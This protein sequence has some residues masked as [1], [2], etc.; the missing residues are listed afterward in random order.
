MRFPLKFVITAAVVCHLLLCAPLVISQARP[1][2]IATEEAAAPQN[3]AD[4]KLPLSATERGPIAIAA[5]SCEK[6]GDT[7]TLTGAVEIQYR[8]YVLRGDKMTYNSGSGGASAVGNVSLDGGPHDAHILADHGDYNVHQQTGKFYE[9]SGTTGARFQGKNVTLTSS[10]PV[11]F[12]GKEV[13]KTGPDE[14]IIYKGSVTSCELPRPK[15]TFSAAKIIVRVGDSA[16]VYNTIFRIRGIPVL[17]LPF[18]A[19]PVESLGRKSGFLVPSLGQ[20][21]TRGF[22]L[23]DSFYWAVNRSTDATVGAEYLSKRGWEL[24]DDFRI[25]PSDTSYLNLNFFGVLDRGVPNSTGGRTDQGGQDVKLNGESIFPHDVRGVVSLEYLSSFVFRQAFT[26]TFS[27]AVDSEVKSTAFLSK[28]FQGFSFNAFGSRYQNFQ[29]TN[30]NDVITILHAPGGESSSVDQRLGKSPLYASYDVAAEG[31]QRTEPGFE[32][33]N[34]VA[35][36]DVLP[37]VSMPLFYK[38]WSFRPEVDVRDT[39]YSESQSPNNVGL[40]VALAQ[41]LNRK[42]VDTSVALRPPTI[43]K[44]FD[45]TFAGRTLKHTLEPSLTYRYTNGVDNLGSTIRFDFRDILSDTNEVEY[46]LVQRLYLKPK[47]EDC[48]EP[49]TGSNSDPAGDAAG[50]EPAGAS[51]FVTWEVKQKYFF[52]PNFGGAVVNGRRNVLATTVDF[53]GIAFLT[54]PRRFSPLVSKL[55][56]RT[57]KNSDLGWQLDYDSKKGRINA[58]TF[59]TTFHFGD[60]FVEGSHAYLQV[61]GEIVTGT[62]QVPLPTCKAGTINQPSCVPGQFNQVRALLGYGKPNK[63]GLS[64][65]GSVGYDYFFK[66]LQYGATQ[67]SYNWD[68]CGVTL[69]Y[70][71]FALLSVRNENQYRFAFTLANIATFGNLK[72]QLRLF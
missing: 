63:L 66:F 1:C 16:K 61:P 26:Q 35:R 72:R 47:H 22:I 25:R 36:F 3:S 51:E 32:T 5:D 21:N 49:G 41:T 57:S 11:A 6:N 24:T 42:T 50:C 18:A 34:L 60:F 53:T 27:Q 46:G 30:A 15:W 62:N 64:A 70:R 23:G 40:G 59:Y 9:V 2:M 68:C 17:Y 12:K 43:G 8:G 67:A 29:S 54:D 4:K 69:E 71:R 44:V 14:Y 20:S 19:P 33:L 65:A 10:S 39:F 48:R 13:E 38:G 7:Y 28:T 56:V 45:R 55:R 58:S 52:D 31:L 37:S